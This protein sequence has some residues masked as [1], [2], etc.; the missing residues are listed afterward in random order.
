MVCAAEN[1]QVILD[2]TEHFRNILSS[3]NSNN[4]I[5]KVYVCPYSLSNTRVLQNLTGKNRRDVK[6]AFQ[7]NKVKTDVKNLTPAPDRPRIFMSNKTS[8]VVVVFPNGEV[9]EGKFVL[10]CSKLYKLPHTIYW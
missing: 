1:A 7:V 4:D 6:M 8:K 5:G 10:T 9:V 3:C 2:Q